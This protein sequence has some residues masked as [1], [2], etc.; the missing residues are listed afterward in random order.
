MID[1]GAESCRALRSLPPIAA[2]CEKFT[3]P[4]VS[5]VVSMDSTT[6]KSSLYASRFTFYQKSLGV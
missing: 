3:L 2:G 1:I 5:P 4:V 6:D